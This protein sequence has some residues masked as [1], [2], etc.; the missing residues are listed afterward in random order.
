MN[1][2]RFDDLELPEEIHPQ[3]YEDE[4]HPLKD[5][6]WMWEVGHL[7]DSIEWMS[8]DLRKQVQYLEEQT[9]VIRKFHYLKSLLEKYGGHTPDCKYMS[10]VTPRIGEEYTSCTCGWYELSSKLK[11]AKRR[12]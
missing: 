7:A 3:Q 8:K 5:E 9:K 2:I 11:R 10:I 1:K 6:E 12:Y 4:P